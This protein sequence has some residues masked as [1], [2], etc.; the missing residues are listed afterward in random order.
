[1][2]EPLIVFFPSSAPQRNI[3][4]L[5]ATFVLLTQSLVPWVLLSALSFRNVP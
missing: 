2:L 3:C 5:A 1:M 4:P